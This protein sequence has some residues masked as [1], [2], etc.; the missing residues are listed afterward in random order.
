MGEALVAAGHAAEL[1]RRV[2]PS[3]A[4]LA[5]SLTERELAILALLPTT[6]SQREL[7]GT[8]FV[9]PNTLKTHLRSI[10]R[11][12]VAHSRD[13]AVLRAR[14]LE[15]LRPGSPGSESPVAAALGM[16]HQRS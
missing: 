3:A 7:A 5:E 13:D 15:L 12:L 2:R 1:A 6:K 4:A 9:S 14:S 16:D 8:L 10:Y 11:K